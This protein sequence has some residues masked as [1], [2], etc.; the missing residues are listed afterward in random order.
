M[1]IRFD[2]IQLSDDGH[3]LYPTIKGTN[4]YLQIQTGTGEVRIGSGNTS[5]VHLSTDRPNFYFSKPISS[6][7]HLSAY[8]GDENLSNWNNVDASAFRSKANTTYLLDPDNTGTSLNVAGAIQLPDAKA[9]MWSG[10]N[11]LSH[12][13]TQTYIGDNTSSSTVT[14][15]GG[16]TTFAGTVS[17]SNLSG[18][19]TGDQTLPTDF[20]SA[21]N[22]GTF[23]GTITASSFIDGG[24][25]T[26]YLDP[27]H[28]TDSLRIKGTIY[29]DSSHSHGNLYLYYNH[30]TVSNS[31]TLTAWVSEPGMTYHDSGIGGNIHK[32]GPY[33][34]RAINDSYGVYINFKKNTG[35][36]LFRN[37]QGNSGTA[38]GQGT[39]RMT[40]GV[41]GDVTA[42]NSFRAPIFYDSN[43]TAYYVN[44]ATGSNLKGIVTN[45]SSSTQGSQLKIYS[46]TH[47]QYPQIHSNAALEAM[48]N[49]KNNTAEWYVGVRTSTQLLGNTGFHFY[50][51]SQGQ[52]VGGWDING[53][54]YSIGSS[55]APIFYDSNNTGYYLNPASTSKTSINIIDGRL[56][57]GQSGD[58][59]STYRLYSAAGG[60]VYFGGH[61]TASS[62]TF[63]G[64]IETSY[65][66]N[67][68]NINL[69][70][71]GNSPIDSGTGG[72]TGTGSNKLLGYDQ[73]NGSGRASAVLGV[74]DQGIVMEY[75]K[76]YTF[77]VSG[78]GWV[79]R[80]TN[81][82]KIL[83]APGADKMIVVE[84]FVVYIDYETRTGIGSS[85]IAYNSDTTAYSIGFFENET[86]QQNMTGANFVVGGSYHTLG[87]MPRDF[88]H[89]STIDRGYYQD[90]PKAKSRLIPNRSIFFKT[91]RNCSSSG[92][93]P[94]GAHYIKVKY[95]ILD[96]S[97]EFN[98]AGCNHIVDSSSYHGRYAH[99]VDLEKNY[100]DAGQ[101]VS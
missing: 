39:T 92:N 47:H 66:A 22:G 43:D 12:N 82:Y 42:S 31:G 44:P 69:A 20:V 90:V 5:Y 95:R 7:G 27:N 78:N 96:I 8:G 32:S 61:M 17:G 80:S 18:T 67:L 53:H 55:R 25:N 85:G 37:T 64:T 83:Q 63:G 52:T 15:T 75:E 81:P 88:V 89:N 28:S 60:Q 35:E 54:S 62:A 9:I 57:I 29:T 26:Y 97:E 11:I 74:N 94:G 51:T 2:E 49:Y 68:G 34:G 91:M 99:D 6:D 59:G 10:N 73:L 33:Y 45:T 16:N 56:T 41:S 58:A 46:T 77:K 21:A 86:G 30:G 50:N 71:I 13:G 76:V 24:D 38:G 84:D 98:N 48:W 65:Y 93:A 70:G 19:N 36:I 72:G 40:I 23:G 4:G 100:N 101:A 1:A 79:N 14:I 3:H 87:T